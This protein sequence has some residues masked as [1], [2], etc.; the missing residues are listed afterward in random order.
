M[1]FNIACKFYV[2]VSPTVIKVQSEL[3]D[4]YIVTFTC[5]AVV[6]THILHY[7][8][9]CS[10]NEIRLYRIKTSSVSK[11]RSQEQCC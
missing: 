11:P 10:C 4:L 1:C 2:S 6:L 8:A 5:I 7:S 9:N 3:K